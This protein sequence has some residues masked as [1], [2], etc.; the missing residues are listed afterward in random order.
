[1]SIPVE[2]R[3]ALQAFAAKE[4]VLLL[5]DFDGVLSD[6]IDDPQQSR[7]REGSRGALTTLSQLPL[8]DVGI[9][10]GRPLADILQVGKPSAEMLVVASHGLEFLQTSPGDDIYKPTAEDTHILSALNAFLSP[11]VH[12]VPGA[13]LEIKPAGIAV[14]TRLCE[15][16]AGHQLL[17]IVRELPD[18]LTSLT[19]RG[20]K[21]VLEFSVSS[22]TKGT[23]VSFLA[24]LKQTENI[25]FI[26]DDVTDEDAF[27][28]LP[29]TGLG[30]KV[31]PGE[32]HAAYRIDST[33]DV[34]EVLE[35]LLAFRTS[36]N[37][38]A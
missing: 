16:G 19:T 1:M 29:A 6:L 10:T 38:P 4:Q 33:T 34:T 18:H 9:V 20:G 7:M 32:T 17:A 24:E 8:T 13:W 2:L 12:A 28:A 22:A 15:P 3:D 36:Q 25:L 26:G 23:A 21:D 27:A 11:L 14:Q 31:G 37:T 5:T 30:I 35:L